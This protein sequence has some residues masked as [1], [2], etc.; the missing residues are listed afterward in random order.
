M[1]KYSKR[2]WPLQIKLL[3][4]F[5]LFGAIILIVLWVFQSFLLKPYYTS[6]KS[7]RVEQSAMRISQSIQ[8]NKNI[9]TTIDNVA[10]SNSLSVYVYDSGSGLMKMLY[11]CTYDVPANELMIE[12]HEIYSYYRSAKNNGGTY[13]AVDTNS[14]ADMAKRKLD[15]LRRAFSGATED[16][17]NA[18]V[19]LRT[20]SEVSSES[21]VCANVIT[22]EDG[23]ER[24][25]L[26]TSSITPLTVRQPQ[27]RKADFKNQQLGKRARKEKLRGRL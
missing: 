16:S 8:Q 26:I 10:S 23:S 21:M 20:Q 12:E 17:V 15:M 6:S 4:Y 22:R 27:N 18:D 11:Q 2:Y 1:K 25:L 14:V 3:G 5:L 24:F 13:M 19:H 7:R 9:W